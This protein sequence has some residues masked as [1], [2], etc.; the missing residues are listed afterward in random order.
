MSTEISTAKP[1]ELAGLI[2]V[3]T[4]NRELIT[5]YIKSQMVEGID[6]GKI[7]V[8]SKD[9]CP[10]QSNCNDPWHYSKDTLFKGGA[11]KFTSLFKLKPQFERDDA[12]WEVMGKK[13]GLF[14]FIC[15]LINGNGDVVA[16][17]R[18]ACDVMEKYGAVNNA[19]KIAEKRAQT[20]AVLR[21]GGLSS[22][23]TQDLDDTEV[24]NVP[25]GAKKIAAPIQGEIVNPVKA[26]APAKMYECAHPE[27]GEAI[28]QAEYDY[29]MKLYKKPLCRLH[30]KAVKK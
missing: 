28:N 29:S 10:K 13:V 6:Y 12:T 1:M 20:D 27:G 16:E 23:F 4:K 18:G 8:V 19:L 17:G 2:A 3:E 24:I 15:K 5:E 26:V 9:K 11:E 25:K 21:H 30:Q 14:C 22:F 7:H